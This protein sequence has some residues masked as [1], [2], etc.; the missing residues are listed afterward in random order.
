M[1]EENKIREVV[2]E[3]ISD[4]LK[5]M[6]RDVSY[7]IGVLEDL[8]KENGRVHTSDLN[9]STHFIDGYIFEDDSPTV[10]SVS[11]TDVQIAY[12][13]EVHEVSDGDTEDKY[14]YWELVSP[15][16]MQTSNDKPTLGG[17]DVL[18]GVN[19][20]GTFEITMVSGKLTPGE[21]LV[22]ESV[23]ENELANDAVSTAKLV[24][25]AVKTGKLDDESVS[26][27]KLAVDSVSTAKIVD[28][29]VKSGKI[30]DG[31]VEEGKLNM[32]THFLF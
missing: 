1:I 28:E 8:K 26:S 27:D 22:D 23:H 5:S 20:D 24:D 16:V 15:G 30:G 7:R 21:S 10:G 9:L 6:L 3:V 13:G 12:Q 31:E 25:G 4:E 2:K 18:V 11:W 32:A 29:A 14:L 17:D 19:D